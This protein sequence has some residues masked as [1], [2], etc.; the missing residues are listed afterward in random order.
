MATSSDIKFIS[1]LIFLE[2]SQHLGFLLGG[3]S[4]SR[5]KPVLGFGLSDRLHS[6]FRF[7]VMFQT[8]ARHTVSRRCFTGQGCGPA[9]VKL[10]WRL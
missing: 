10:S 7:S 2:A 4:D 8:A 3:G 9:G 1:R 5:W 6:F